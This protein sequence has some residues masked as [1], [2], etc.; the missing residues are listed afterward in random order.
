MNP[1]LKNS[2]TGTHITE[3]S[4]ATLRED[5]LSPVLHQ[6]VPLVVIR[7]GGEVF[8]YHD[9][10]PHAFWPLSEGALS[11]GVL[12]CPGHGWE[13]DVATGRCLNA[14]ANCLT[15]VTVTVEGDIVR[16]AWRDAEAAKQSASSP[17]DA[18]ST[19]AS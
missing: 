18:S 15:A 14:P 11:A 10:C 1:I 4:L 5:S 17:R 9:R 13:F 6:G 7:T 2:T 19:T 3:L 8:A 12:E 16:L